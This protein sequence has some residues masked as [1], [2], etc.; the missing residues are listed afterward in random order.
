MAFLALLYGMRFEP[1]RP[2]QT[3]CAAPLIQVP[4]GNS[5]RSSRFPRLALPHG[6]EA[7]LVLGA[8]CGSRRIDEAR[9]EH[10][11]AIG[12]HFDVRDGLLH[13]VRLRVGRHIGG[14]VGMAHPAS[15]RC[16]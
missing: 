12:K 14:E 8:P 15:C 5:I 2:L 13:L 7:A 6:F 1:F 16:S 3:R 9:L 4:S 11:P 10:F